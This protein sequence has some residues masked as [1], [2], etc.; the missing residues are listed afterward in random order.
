M[1]GGGVTDGGS[2]TAD[3]PLNSLAPVDLLAAASADYAEFFNLHGNEVVD[4]G[5]GANANARICPSHTFPPILN[6]PPR[7]RSRIGV[8]MCRVP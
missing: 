4:N 8:Y 5:L 7:A 6:C 3:A 1:D 2:R